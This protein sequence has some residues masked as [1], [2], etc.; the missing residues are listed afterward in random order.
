M[1][2]DEQ[3]VVTG[4]EK[5]RRRQCNFNSGG[6]PARRRS[7]VKDRPSALIV[8]LP[9]RSLGHNAG[10]RSAVRNNSRPSVH[11]Y[12]KSSVAQGNSGTVNTVRRR[13]PD[14]VVPLAH[15]TVMAP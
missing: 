15:R 2:L 11:Q 7:A 12:C 10:E 14:P 13:G 8:N 3:R 4:L 6:R 9:P 5:M 1:L